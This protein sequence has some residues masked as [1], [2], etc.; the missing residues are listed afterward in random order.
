MLENNDYERKLMTRILIDL[1]LLM[2]LVDFRITYLTEEINRILKKWNQTS[3]ND[4]LTHSKD[5]TLSMA[6]VDAVH[7]KRL[8][9]E[10]EDFNKKKQS[11]RS[12]KKQKLRLSLTT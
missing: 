1:K 2:D 6:E 12:L 3:L 9:D 4:F 10:M 11:W 8:M 5:G 7:I